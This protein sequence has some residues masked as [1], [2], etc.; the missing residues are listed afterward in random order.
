M[1]DKDFVFEYLVVGKGL[2]GAAAAKYLSTT[3]HGPVALV[4]PDEP[5]DYSSAS[6]FASHYDSTRVQRRVGKDAV[7]TRLN[8]ESLAQYLALEEESGMHFQS[9]EGCLYVCP[10]GMDSYLKSYSSLAR[11]FKPQPRLINGVDLARDFPLYSFPSTARAVFETA[12]SGHINPRLLVMAQLAVFEKKGGSVF[13]ETI[14]KVGRR[15]GFFEIQSEEGKMWRAKNVLVAAGSFSNFFGLLPRK[16]K[17]ILKSE[18]VLLARV[19]KAEAARLEQLPSLLYEIVEK[20][21]DG[22]YMVRPVQ[23]PDGHFY[24]KMGSNL[25]SDIFFGSLAEI[26]AWF[27]TGNSDGNKNQLSSILKSILPSVRTEGLHTKGCIITRTPE[28]RPYIDRID[29]GL[30]V[31]TGGN[32]FAAM[33]SDALGKAA[34]TLVLT[35]R[36]PE[37]YPRDAFTVEYEA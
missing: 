37:G 17:T 27:K 28:G 35:G 7:W 30:F 10:E 34:A 19:S 26:Q 22:V 14:A 4:G 24:L 23:Y 21:F 12:P 36:L 2:I 25:S 20:E 16:F 1:S 6:V 3:G 15:N 11:D 9:Q 13:R 32:G 8:E 31:A 18:T 5:V 29:E 33:C